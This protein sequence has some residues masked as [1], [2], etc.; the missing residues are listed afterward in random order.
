VRSNA[1][2][3]GRVLNAG[4]AYATQPLVALLVVGLL[5]LLLRWTF[6]RGSSLVAAPPRRGGERDY[7][8][9][10]PIASPPTFV[11][12]ELIRAALVEHGVRATL[13]PTTDGPR[14]LVFAE[15]ARAAR[16]VLRGPRRSP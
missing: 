4:L 8:L 13:A 2:Q 15:E 5:V 6:R 9:L 11:E 1:E 7:G 14:V 12:A 10:V 16:A 3:T